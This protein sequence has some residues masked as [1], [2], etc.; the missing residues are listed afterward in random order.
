MNTITIAINNEIVCTYSQEYDALLT[1]DSLIKDDLQLLY[2]KI[3]SSYDKSKHLTNYWFEYEG[4]V[5]DSKKEFTC[6][7]NLN[8]D[9]KIQIVKRDIYN[10]GSDILYD[11]EK[12]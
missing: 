12:L 9:M 10:T 4:C 7:D 1:I 6:Q 8:F 2:K 3:Y 5:F 11:S